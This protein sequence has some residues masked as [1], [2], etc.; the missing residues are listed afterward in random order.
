MFKKSCI[1]P[2]S[3]SSQRRNFSLPCVYL[4]RGPAM[5]SLLGTC[6]VLGKDITNDKVSVEAGKILPFDIN[7]PCKI[8]VDLSKGGRAWL[9]DPS[10]AGTT[11]WQE[12][13]QRIF[14]EKPRTILIIG[15]SDTGKSTLATYIINLAL[16]RAYT[17]AIVDGDVGQ[18]DLAP[19]NAIGA[20]VVRDQITDLREINTHFFEFVGNINPLGFEDVII[21]AIKN[22]V[23]E[24]S[25]HCN[26]CI[27]NTDGYILNKGID[28]K[29]R[30][31]NELR[32]DVVIHLGEG[33]IFE[34]FKTKFASSAI[35]HGQPP[36]KT[37]KSKIE[38]RK[39]RLSQ[40]L[41]YISED[42]EIKII[43]KELKNTK[44]V[45]KGIVYSK[46]CKDHYRSLKLGHRRRM[47]VRP[48][49]LLYMF[50]GLGYREEIIGFGIITNVS[51]HRITIQT[52]IDNF[53]KIYLSSS[54]IEIIS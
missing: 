7:S 5:V 30:L 27:I 51:S 26:L 52:P 54:K 32:A 50:V 14:I 41:R 34:N 40:F 1:Y 48:R 22:A 20:A 25:S 38:R 16:K 37:V 19:P 8:H 2:G 35:L 6:H 18:G 17:P 24:I 13:I 36:C 28:Y 45:Y 11:I 46:T 43:T 3:I 10:N 42:D 49:K 33:S 12:I 31:A 4:V 15:E 53:N 39:R 23:K 44:F 29:V 9:S 21:K 47:R